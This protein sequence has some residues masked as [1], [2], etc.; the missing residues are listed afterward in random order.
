MIIVKYTKLD[1]LRYLSFLDI[2][3]VF[4]RTLNRAK[5]FTRLSQGFNPHNLVYFHDPDSLGI[6]S[7][8]D[9]AL[10][11]CDFDIKDF[12]KRFN[13]S[14]P[15]GLK[16]EFCSKSDKIIFNK[17]FKYAKYVIKFENAI[18]FDIKE[19]DFDEPICI[20]NNDKTKILDLKND[21]YSYK[22]KDDYTL[23]LTLSY[24]QRKLNPILLVDYL[25]REKENNYKIIK[26]N[27]YTLVDDNLIDV[28]S[29]FFNS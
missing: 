7:K 21:L 26:E 27:V 5:I 12:K 23:E 16:I 13:D 28:D 2:R 10:I 6:E 1:T 11:D 29:I 19:L 15:N 18:D 8:S 3:N 20:V 17:I 9:Y 25:L 24:G 14:S 22:L 4:Q